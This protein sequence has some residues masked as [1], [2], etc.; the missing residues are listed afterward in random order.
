M[1]SV[2]MTTEGT[3]PYGAGGVSTW[4]DAL[5]RNT[6]AVRYTLLPVMMNPHIEA[7]FDPPSNVKKIVAVARW[8]IEEP[9]EFAAGVPF[10]ELYKRKGRTAAAQIENEF[11]PLFERFLASVNNGGADAAAF[12]RVLVEMED[13]FRR[14]DYNETMKSPPVCEAFAG[15]MQSNSRPIAPGR[16]PAAHDHPAPT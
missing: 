6:P 7:K 5:V 13:Y 15:T 3:Y 11:V 1:L 2:L 14:R 10:A 9:G 12:G 16:P 8:G 4:C